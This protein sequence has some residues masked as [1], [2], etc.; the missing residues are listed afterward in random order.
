MKGGGGGGGGGEGGGGK[1]SNHST[2][3]IGLLAGS[4]EKEPGLRTSF[5]CV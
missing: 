5:V 3:M 2:E 1:R 4:Q